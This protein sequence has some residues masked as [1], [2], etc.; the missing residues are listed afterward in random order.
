MQAVC[1]ASYMCTSLWLQPP[2]A[3]GADNWNA[4]VGHH[5]NLKLPRSRRP[6]NNTRSFEP[7]YNYS[8]CRASFSGC[9]LDVEVPSWPQV[10][11]VY[12]LHAF[13]FSSKIN[14][15]FQDFHSSFSTSHPHPDTK[16]ILKNQ[17]S[18]RSRTTPNGTC[19]LGRRSAFWLG[20]IPDCNMVSVNL[21]Q[22]VA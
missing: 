17:M 14:S 3:R 8:S 2:R 5:E 6:R 9:R 19:L 10:L 15:T 13:I 4:P 21:L 7:V 1:H 16:P 22:R 18:Q 12:S 20:P 11:G